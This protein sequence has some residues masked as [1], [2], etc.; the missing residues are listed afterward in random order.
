MARTIF[1][2]FIYGNFS[3]DITKYTVTF[4]VY[5]YGPGQPYSCLFSLS[6]QDSLRFPAR[7][8]CFILKIRCTHSHALI[9]LQ[10]G[11]PEEPPFP[12]APHPLY[13]K[14]QMVH[15]HTHSYLFS[16]GL[17][18]SLRFPARLIRFM[19]PLHLV[20]VSLLPQLPLSG[21]PL[22]LHPLLMPAPQ[23]THQRQFNCG[24]NILNRS[25]A[26]AFGLRLPFYF[27]RAS[28]KTVY[29]STLFSSFC[30]KVSESGSQ[31]HTH[32]G[33]KPA[34]SVTALC[35]YSSIFQTHL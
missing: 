14:N 10:L 11:P 25:I 33:L 17:Q 3:R 21:F 16:L 26:S 15:I 29:V 2:R 24:R 1:L 12:C 7:L 6:L 8:I 19:P 5:I 22:K 13:S 23:C 20:L 34:I 18:D 28:Y 31:Q 30:Q 27:Y 9:P 32:T 35:A 4:D